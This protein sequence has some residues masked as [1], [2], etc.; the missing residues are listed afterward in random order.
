MASS[1]RGPAS[2]TDPASASASVTPWRVA[3]MRSLRLRS[4]RSRTKA[5][6]RTLPLTQA[7]KTATSTG[8]S[9]PSARMAID[10][11]RRPRSCDSPV[12]TNSR[13]RL[14]TSSRSA[15]GTSLSMASRPKSSAL[16]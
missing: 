8:K 4:V 3:D 15:G 1:R 11:R 10:S 13:S 12:V 14:R 7:G 5:V 16:V 9:V 2:A 6:S